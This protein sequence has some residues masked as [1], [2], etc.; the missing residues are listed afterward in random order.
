MSAAIIKHDS[1]ALF[2]RTV[3]A[4]GRAYGGFQWPMEANAVVTAPDWEQTAECGAGL[5][6]LLNG[7]GDSGYLSWSDDAVWQVVEASESIDLDGKHK[8]RACVLRAVGDRKSVTDWLVLQRHGAVVHGATAT[9][10]DCGTATAGDCGTATAGDCGTATSGYRGTA[11]AG[12]GGTATAGNYGAATAGDCGTATAGDCG[13]AT[14]GDCGTAT[15]GDCGTAT[16]GDCGEIR[17]R[18]HDDTRYRLAV[19]YVG[20]GGIEPDVAYRCDDSGKLVRS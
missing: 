7:E 2:L 20:E 19:G 4:V 5:H 9:A 8:F 17:I 1:P 6:G 10:G 11:T 3:D 12:N 15:A 13:T 14:A 18:W 16:S